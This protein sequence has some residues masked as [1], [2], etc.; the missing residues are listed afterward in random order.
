M[1]KLE[2]FL[3]WSLKKKIENNRVFSKTHAKKVWGPLNL[4]KDKRSSERFCRSPNSLPMGNTF[5]IDANTSKHFYNYFMG[6]K[7]AIISH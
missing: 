5:L 3:G 6:M 2:E 7:Q 4:P 1:L